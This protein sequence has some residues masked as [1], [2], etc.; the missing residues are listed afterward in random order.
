MKL[1]PCCMIQREKCILRTAP[2]SHTL[3]LISVMNIQHMQTLPSKPSSYVHLKT[4]C[5]YILVNHFFNHKS[6]AQRSVRKGISSSSTYG[7]ACMR[8]AVFGG[9]GLRLSALG[10]GKGRQSELESVFGVSFAAPGACRSDAMLPFRRRNWKPSALGVELESPT[11][12]G[13]RA[14]TVPP[15]R[16][17]ERGLAPSTGATAGDRLLLPRWRSPPRRH[18]RPPP[19]PLGSPPGASGSPPPRRRRGEGEEGG[20]R[21]AATGKE[22]DAEE[23]RPPPARSPPPPCSSTM[24]HRRSTTGT[25]VGHDL[26]LRRRIYA[27]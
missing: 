7:H 10:T 9:G 25:G 5:L 21:S 6:T 8:V 14:P 15:R 20:R 1:P 16:P 18:T 11:R 2:N 3:M 19:H 27:A 26:V 4:F 23:V 22:R 24:L 13:S 17:P 12:R